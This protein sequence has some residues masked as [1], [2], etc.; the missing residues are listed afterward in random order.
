MLPAFE[1]SSTAAA[2]A[3]RNK[4]ARKKAMY[5]QLVATHNIDFAPLAMSTFGE[6]GEDCLEFISQAVAFYCAKHDLPRAEGE[7][8]FR[9]QLSA[10]PMRQVGQRLLAA[11]P[12]C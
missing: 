4:A 1:L 6:L 3:V 2:A 5:A 7:T 9:Q 12:L 11:S 10:E 8:Q